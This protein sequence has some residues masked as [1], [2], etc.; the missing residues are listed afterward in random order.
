M[1]LEDM[2]PEF[3]QT[4]EYIHR[5]IEAKVAEQLC[6]EKKISMEPNKKRRHFRF[7][8]AAA[9][10]FAAVM[11]MGSTV[12]AG[13]KLYQIYMEKNGAYGVQI[14]VEPENAEEN[15]VLPDKVPEIEIKTGYLPEGMIQRGDVSKTTIEYEN[16]PAKGGITMTTVLLDTDE[17][18][19]AANDTYVVSSELLSFDGHDGVYLERKIGDETEI[20]FDKKICLVY[21]EVRRVLIMEIANNV[22][23]EEALKV[24]KETE[25]IDTGKVIDTKGLWKWSDY[26]AGGKEE[27]LEANVFANKVVSLKMK[28][29]HSIGESFKVPSSYVN[30]EGKAGW[31]EDVEAKVVSVEISD[32]LSLLTEEYIPEEWKTAVDSEGKLVQNELTYYKRGDGIDTLDE[33]V[34]TE[35]A[36]QKLVHITLEY[37][38]T[39]DETL[40]DILFFGSLSAIR[41]DA[42]TYELIDYYNHYGEEEWNY[43]TGSSV[44]RLGEMPCHDVGGKEGKN[45]ISSLNPGESAVVHMAWIVN[46]TDLDEIYL[47]LNAFGEAAFDEESLEIGYVDIRQ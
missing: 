2:K 7:S 32:N 35:I 11:L 3:P 43:R 5:M 28:N 41:K 22:T 19:V 36:E 13:V 9:I 17:S 23:K 42:D 38:N 31:S 4:P 21:P 29:L 1:R 20:V 30:A 27:A 25:L 45:Y 46:E 12:Y 16:A 10:A 44:A 24:A 39:G 14:V 34:K 18:K 33:V 6:E 15:T 37:K 8:K 26:A 40:N 47:N